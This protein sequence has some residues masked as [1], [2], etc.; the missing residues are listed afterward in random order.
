MNISE[1]MQHVKIRAIIAAIE[2]PDILRARMSANEASAIGSL[3]SDD[4]YS[5]IYSNDT[6]SGDRA[7]SAPASAAQNSPAL[8]PP[9]KA[10][11]E[12]DRPAEPQRQRGQAA[13]PLT[14]LN[15]TA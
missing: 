2:I 13:S 1:H 5:P 14:G 15:I 7:S 3:T 6:N 11:D 10:A 4:S 12:P 8:S 9:I